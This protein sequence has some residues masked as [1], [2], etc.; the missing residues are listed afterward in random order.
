MVTVRRLTLL[1][2][3]ALI[4]TPVAASAH[5]GGKPTGT[6]KWGTAFAP[7]YTPA[8]KNLEESRFEEG[9]CTEAARRSMPVDE[10][11]NHLAIEQHRFSC[12]MEQV[13]FDSLT[14]TF[15]DRPD[16][17]LGEMDVKGHLAVVAIAYP[18]SG[19]LLYD[20]SDASK[21][22]LLSHYEGDECEGLIM[23]VDCGAFVDLSPDL[24]RVYISVQQITVIPGPPGVGTQPTLAYPGVD[25][26]DISD[27]E[28][29]SLLQKLPV[30]S[31]G[32]VHTTRSFDVPEGPSS[33]DAP[34]EPGSYTVSV[35]NSV[36]ATIMKANAL[37]LEPVTTIE[38]AELHDTF[39]QNDPLTGRTLL[40]IAAG[41]DTGFY[42]YDVTAP[43]A[44]V[45][46]AEWDL[47]PECKNDWYSHTIDVAI[48]GGR[49]YVTLPVELIDF[50]GEQ[51]EEDQAEGCGTLQG[52]GD[53]SGPL[54]IVDATDLSELGPADPTGN[55]G[56]TAE[57]TAKLKAASEDVLT[58][59][60]SNAANRAGGELT[61]S[62]HNQQIVG[63]R[64]YLSGYHS[65]VTVLDASAAFRGENIRPKEVA[66]HVPSAEPTR[67]IHPEA[68][69]TT[70]LFAPFFTAFLHYRPLIWDMTYVNGHLLAA[71][72]VGGFYSLREV[73]DPPPTT[74]PTPTTPAPPTTPATPGPTPPQPAECRDTVAP[75]STFARIRLTRTKVSVRG[76]SRD[77]GC[78]TLDRV[79]VAVARQVD[80]KRCHFLLPNGRYS[81]IRRC[82]HPLYQVAKGTSRWSFER[83]WR[84]RRGSHLV[85]VRAF[86]TARN[87][88]PVRVHDNGRRVRVR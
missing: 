15:A 62:P 74:P 2:L 24:Q 12:R 63:D 39:I 56:N 77:T 13:A 5:V 3:L 49:R 10:G 4:A 51:D 67:P 37:G 6:F 40:Y 19:F 38:L 88:E 52:N 17:S 20:I 78:A 35:A 68:G 55:S 27:P 87:R 47:T 46:L 54:W 30:E 11:H 66:L 50:F 1:A 29:P 85:F 25:V 60:W 70:P 41:F 69:G 8:M 79:V 34:R 48:R 86:D 31:V 26:I 21:P 7:A 80:R 43:S 64:I 81:T 75:R 84:L 18:Q 22:K 9:P 61:F 36:G 33:A 59:T 58:A 72:M 45:L 53:M 16:V 73:D 42:V 57:D 28:T 23:D 14:E 82:A 71:D 44:P 65:G 76:T 32:G 83:S